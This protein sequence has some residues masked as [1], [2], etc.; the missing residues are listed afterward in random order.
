M[1]R[2]WLQRLGLAVALANVIAI[3]AG[4]IFMMKWPFR[5]SVV[6]WVVWGGLLQFLPKPPEKLPSASTRI[7]D[8]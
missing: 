3:S 6:L 7:L 2:S 1:K 5:V 8:I 4:M